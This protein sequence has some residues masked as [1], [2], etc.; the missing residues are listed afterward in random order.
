MAETRTLVVPEPDIRELLVRIRGVTPLLCD[1]GA[2]ALAE[3]KQHRAAK[4]GKK[5]TVPEE[6]FESSLYR[7]DGGFGFPAAAIARALRD[8]SARFVDKYSGKQV[9]G[10]IRIKSTGLLPLVGASKPRLD[11][12]AIITK[13]RQDIA[14]RARF[15]KWE[16][17][18]P[19]VHNA[20]VISAE[21]ILALFTHAGFGVGIGAWRPECN[22][23]YG[24]FE[25]VR[26]KVRV[27]V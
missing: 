25:V 15:D 10:A 8:A 16:I 3:L 19:I 24:Q 12:A 26:D 6:K 20:S 5:Q 17:D 7:L 22:G 2:Q 14:Y 1:N 21:Q 13:R 18:V 4:A 9:A 23:S 27:T 11:E